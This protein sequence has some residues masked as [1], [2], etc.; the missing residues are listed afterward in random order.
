MLV[1]TL[2]QVDTCGHH[3]VSEYD[4]VV[5]GYPDVCHLTIDVILLLMSSYY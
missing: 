4:K 1:T 3:E 2:G 5:S